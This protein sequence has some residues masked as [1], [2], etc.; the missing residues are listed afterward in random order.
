MCTRG[1]AA[2]ERS[3]FAV[4]G[5]SSSPMGLNAA[6]PNSVHIFNG[7]IL[8]NLITGYGEEEIRNLAGMLTELGLDK[9]IDSFPSGIMTLIGE[10]GINLSGGQ[11]QIIAFIRALIRKPEILVIDEGTSGMDR[12]T[13]SMIM[14]LLLRLKKGMLILLI[15][16]R[17]NM[18]RDIS[19]RIYV[20]EDKGIVADGSHDELM[21]FDNLY[22]RFWDDFH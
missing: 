20:M 12:G 15:S 10:E 2:N 19:D 6:D 21:Q 4:M 13:E 16:H 14:N 18:I 11:K 3:S 8:Q 7:T 17:V 22:K 1:S 5:L 9:F